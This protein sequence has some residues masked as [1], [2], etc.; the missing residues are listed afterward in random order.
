M[1]SSHISKAK[2][3]EEFYTQIKKISNGYYTDWQ[4]TVI[5]YSTYHYM[6]AFLVFKKNAAA[7]SHAEMKIKLEKVL[8]KEEQNLFTAIYFNSRMSRYDVLSNTMQEAIL[9]SKLKE[10]QDFFIEIKRILATNY[11]L[12]LN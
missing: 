12:N 6:N 3:N 11:K 8:K 10:S 1:P 9:K 2:H 5:F 4:I 7:K